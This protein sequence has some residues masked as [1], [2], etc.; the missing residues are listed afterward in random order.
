MVAM[1]QDLDS[2]SFPRRDEFDE[3]HFLKRNYG[4]RRS[5]PSQV[6]FLLLWGFAFAVHVS[7]A[8]GNI[9][10]IAPTTP[11]DFFNAGTQ[12]LQQGKLREA[13]ALL[14][15]AVASQAEALQ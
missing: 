12:K 10:E 14:E 5:R 3:S 1:F 11:R 8:S 15:N 13:E 7:A 4:S 2:Y 9:A 6:C